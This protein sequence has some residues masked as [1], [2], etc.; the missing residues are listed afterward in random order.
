MS[1]SALLVA[2]ACVVPRPAQDDAAAP[3]ADVDRPA[4]RAALT[5]MADRLEDVELITAAYRQERQT[6]LLKKPIVSKG[7]LLLRREPACMLMR[8]EEPGRAIL[9]SDATSHLSWPGGDRPAE[10]FLF[11]EDET[12]ATLLRCL[13]GD[14]RGLEEAFTIASYEATDELLTIG[15]VPKD[16]ALRERLPRLE[17]GLSPEEALPAAVEYDTREHETVTIRLDDV[18]AD[19]DREADDAVFDDPLPDGVPI[20]TRRL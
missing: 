7:R 9:R 5:R 16:E 4:A 3:A 20:V 8:V 15:L 1:P 11:E 19:P 6:F 2:L 17:L 14:V 18:V 13:T 10:R 12:V